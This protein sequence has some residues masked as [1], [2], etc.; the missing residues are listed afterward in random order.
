MLSWN[1]KEEIAKL[2]SKMSEDDGDH[3]WLANSTIVKY[4]SPGR[5]AIMASLVEDQMAIVEAQAMAAALSSP[6]QE[7][8]R[9]EIGADTTRPV[10]ESTSPA[11]GATGVSKTGP[12]SVTFSERVLSGTVDQTTIKLIANG[13]GAAD[14]ATTSV[15]AGVDGVEAVLTM[16]GALTGNT[17]YK[18]RVTVAVT[19][20]AGN[21]LLAEYTSAT[22]FTTVA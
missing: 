20:L 2:M 6:V 19:D 9:S 13:G 10:I 8:I 7:K 22:G 17:T 3:D 21:A 11:A 4:S 15:D 5:V 16:A 18:F 14:V 12:F 1:E